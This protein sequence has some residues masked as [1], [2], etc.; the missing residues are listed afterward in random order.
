MQPMT[1]GRRTIAWPVGLAAAVLAAWPAAA[2]DPPPA[3]P[4]PPTLTAC[5]AIRFALERNPELAAARLQH[6]IAAAGAVIARAYPFNPV[7]EGRGRAAFGPPSA[8][9]DNPFTTENTLLFEVEL[10]G[11]GR[12]R[13]SAA[14]AALS[15]TDWEI[16][17]REL[18]VSIR[19]V[20][21]FDT[22]VYRHQK[23]Q[24]LLD[25]VKLNEQLLEKAKGLRETKLLKP[26]DVIVLRTEVTDS[27]AAVGQGRTALA[28]AW[29]DLRRTLGAVDECFLVRGGLNP[30]PAPGDCAA[31][32][33]AAV[34]ARPDVQAR[35]AAVAEADA[36]LR[37]EVANRFGNLTVGPTYEYDPTRINLP[38]VQFA[39]PLPV[40][41]THRGE[42]LQ[43]QAERAL[44]GA[45]LRQAEVQARQDV[46]AAL[47]R[48]REARRWADYY[49][50]DVLPDLEK[51][52]NEIREL[53]KQPAEV[54][55]VSA[56]N[57]LDV[58]R[59][60]L[61]ARDAQLDAL[62]EVRQAAADLAAAVGD[63]ALAVGPCPRP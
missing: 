40:L 13:R 9:V 43:R 56:L 54:S 4:P 25:T 28:V 50:T 12:Y 10:R 17:A 16:A 51:S 11:Q 31:L 2:E 53:L 37:L 42:I 27:Q 14:A 23:L 46:R 41:N 20:R 34:E 58:Q 18:D 57:L 5:D 22:V 30:P 38:G 19:V 59:K 55:G 35:R 45:E 6:G 62:F 61:H 48:L 1:A 52:L 60:L 7:W 63:P 32:A 15:R 36:R 3:P 47:D 44:A 29:S 21:A 8:A 39:V 26:A 24:V 49:A 33:D